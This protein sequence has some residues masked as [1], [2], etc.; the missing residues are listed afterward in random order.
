MEA[1]RKDLSKITELASLNDCLQYLGLEVGRD[2]KDASDRHELGGVGGR[3][4]R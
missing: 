2:E 1:E 4:F 3:D